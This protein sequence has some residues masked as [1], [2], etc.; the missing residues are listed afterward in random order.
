MI[1][2]RMIVVAVDTVTGNVRNLGSARDSGPDL[3]E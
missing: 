2:K 3:T 1:T